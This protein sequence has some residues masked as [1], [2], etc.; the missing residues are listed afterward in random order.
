MRFLPNKK[1]VL[2]L[3]I[4]AAAA[5]LALSFDS[6]VRPLFSRSIMRLLGLVLFASVAASVVLLQS[7]SRPLERIERLNRISFIVVVG[8]VL[9]VCFHYSRFYFLGQGYP[10]STFLFRPDDR[11]M[12]YFNGLTYIIHGYGAGMTG[13]SGIAYLVWRF[14]YFVSFNNAAVSFVVYAI[15]MTLYVVWYNFKGASLLQMFPSKMV[16]NVF[17]LSFLSYPV[18]FTLDRGNF[19]GLVFILLSLFIYFFSSNRAG[20]STVFLAAASALKIYPVIFIILFIA[21]RKYKETLLFVVVLLFFWAWTY[22][23]V[24]GFGLR[25]SF[26][27]SLIGGSGN[28][29]NTYNA[30]YVIGDEGAGFCSSAYGA[31]KGMLY[32]W[33]SHLLVSHVIL[34][35][36]VYY[37]A[38]LFFLGVVALYVIMIEKEF[39]RRVAI[40]V[41]SMILFPFVTGDYR[42]LHLYIPMW[43]F[44]NLKTQDRNDLLYSIL[45][46]LLLIPK[47]YYFIKGEISVSVVLNPLIIS[48]LMALLITEGLRSTS[49]QDIRKTFNQ[50][51]TAIL[52]LFALRKNKLTVQGGIR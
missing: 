51:L 1:I 47:A 39:W 14:L 44:L 52:S 36:R 48:V 11:F 16:Q 26:F 43:L 8:F 24:Q 18:L 33:Y 23:N 29:Q 12:D 49:V 46:A 20:I 6:A 22:N 45:F 9:S 30:L 38:S 34:L 17:V 37:W 28:T 5:L 10:F 19:E 35:A 27:L 15:A 31:L 4:I 13:T 40:V 50:H 21:D 32:F 42:L 2:I 7:C 25:P 3:V 41:L